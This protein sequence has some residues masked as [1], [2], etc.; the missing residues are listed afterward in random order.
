MGGARD[1]GQLGV[2]NPSVEGEGVFEVDDV[3]VAGHDQSSGLDTGEVRRRDR[4]LM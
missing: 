4:W 3:V 1:H 2:F